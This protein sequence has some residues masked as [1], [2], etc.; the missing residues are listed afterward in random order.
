MGSDPSDIEKRLADLEK[1]TTDVN[2]NKAEKRDIAEIDKR[3]SGIE[4][5]LSSTDSAKVDRKEFVD[6]EKRI[7]SLETKIAV[8]AGIAIVIGLGG[9]GI[10]GILLK[11]YDQIENLSAQV[12]KQKTDYETTK[13]N[14]IKE[15]TDAG[16]QKVAEIYGTSGDIISRIKIEH[17]Q[18]CTGEYDGP[19]APLRRFDPRDDSPESAANKICGTMKHSAPRQTKISSGG[20]CGYAWYDLTC[21]G[22]L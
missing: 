8:A 17:H 16:K 6:L 10:G 9:A 7:V 18:F 11:A 2:Y 22:S 5:R 12:T 13:L 4:T 19:C 3:M 1:V 20:C 14:L 15:I 21:Y